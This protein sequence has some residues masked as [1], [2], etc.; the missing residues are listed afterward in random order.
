MRWIKKKSSVANSTPLVAD[1]LNAAQ[2]EALLDQLKDV[3]IIF[4][5]MLNPDGLDRFAYWTNGHRGMNP[6]HD[7]NDREHTEAVP[8][9]RTNYYWFDLNRDWLPHQHPES[10]GR[11][12]LFH[13][14]KPNAYFLSSNSWPIS[15]WQRHAHEGKIYY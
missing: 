12:A 5:P 9:G 1:Y 14:W 4:N 3:V 13:E 11:L 6:S 7:A 15:I 8:N 10:R 2:D